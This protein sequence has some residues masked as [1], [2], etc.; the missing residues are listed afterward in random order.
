MLLLKNKNF[1]SEIIYILKKLRMKILTLLGTRPEIIRLSVIIKKLNNILGKNHVV[2]YSNQNFDYKLSKVFFGELGLLTPSY[3]FGDLEAKSVGEFLSKGIEKFENVLNQEKPDK[4][5]I[6]GDT[7][8][9]LLAMLASK[10]GIPVY[11]MEAGNRSFDNRVPEE[12]NRKIIDSF[13]KVN[14]PY[15]ENSKQNLLAE[16]YHKNFVFKIG[17]PIYEV[18]NEYEEGIRNSMVIEKLKLK[19]YEYVLVTAHRSE[20]VDDDGNLIE[21]YN[22]LNEIAKDRKVVFSVHPRTKSKLDKLNLEFNDNIILSEPFGFFDFVKLEKNCH[23]GI[24]DCL[25]PDTLTVLE[26]GLIKSFNELKTNDSI[27]SLNN[28]N[29]IKIIATKNVNKKYKITTKYNEIYCSENHKLFIQNGDDIKEIKIKNLKK[30]DRLVSFCKI[31]I[32]NKNNI[33]LK[34]IEQPDYVKITDEG[35]SFLKIYSDGNPLKEFGR[36]KTNTIRLK[37]GV[38]FKKLKEVLDYLSIEI[39]A[40]KKFIYKSNPSHKRQHNIIQSKILTNELATICGFLCGD[41]LNRKNKNISFFDENEEN[42]IL[43]NDIIKKLFGLSSEIKC[44]KRSVSGKYI[45]Y[46]SKS[47]SN[48]FS[49][50]FP[51]ESENTTTNKKDISDIILMSSNEIVKHYIRGLF[52]AE[53]FV[54]DH[55]IAITMSDKP[56]IYKLK[57][58]L[59]R[60][61]IISNIYEFEPRRDRDK[62]IMYQL[63]IY[64]NESRKIFR[65]EIGFISSYKTNNLNNLFEKIDRQSRQK[66]VIRY[67]NIFFDLIRNIEI[68]EDEYEYIDINVEPNNIFLANGLL[69]HNSG[70]VQEELQIFKVPSITIRNTTERQETIENG[71]TILTGMNYKKMID[72]F[73]TIKYMT[74]NWDDISD[75]TVENVSDRVIK[76]LLSR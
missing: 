3:Y 43:I 42:L 52:E 30:S 54:G 47:L 22:F 26:N 1:L 8:T 57:Y 24:T 71:S 12:T 6:L 23:V 59:L 70:T 72:A 18:L 44:D 38:D 29:D 40:F 73:N 31:N 66:P 49:L 28:C 27:I 16:G 68:I 39:D 7:N 50:N 69:S 21:L 60:F 10:R 46:S 2:V 19:Y 4:I 11:H 48:Y 67:D 15:T 58:L 63:A 56:V 34:E 76:I 17:N 55:H 64:E 75:Y 32:N 62:S 5:L 36:F 45:R 41:G 74:N 37:K 61:G 35:I 65:D 25:R 9:G 13:S 14:L 51:A 53:G 20:N 33:T